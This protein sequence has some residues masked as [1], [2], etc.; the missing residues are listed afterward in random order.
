[1]TVAEIQRA[2][3]E[4]QFLRLLRDYGYTVKCRRDGFTG[5]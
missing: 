2:F 5:T 4:A 1:M 3:G